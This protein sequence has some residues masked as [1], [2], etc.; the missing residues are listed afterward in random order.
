MRLVYGAERQAAAETND[1]QTYYEIGDME[2]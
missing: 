2:P 1:G